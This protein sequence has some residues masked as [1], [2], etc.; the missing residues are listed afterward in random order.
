[1]PHITTDL[2]SGGGL[3]PARFF[4]L[5]RTRNQLNHRRGNRK[6]EP[7]ESIDSTKTNNLSISRR[8]WAHLFWASVRS[9]GGHSRPGRR[10]SPTSTRLRA[11]THSSRSHPAPTTR[12]AVI[13]LFVTTQAA[14]L[15]QPLGHK[16]FYATPSAYETR[17][18]ERLR[19]LATRLAA[20]CW[21][22]TRQS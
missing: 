13:E 12:P 4:A 1:M 7:Y 16:R 14:T 3:S 8:V 20:R 21:P 9:A 11:L 2:E 15:T 6:A 10:I 19:C 18:M 17:P 22:G 5:F